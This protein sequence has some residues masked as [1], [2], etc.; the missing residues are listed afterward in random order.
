[1]NK[2]DAILT[3]DWHL[4]EDTPI[5]RTDNF[6]E[7]QWKKVS[8]VSNLQKKYN[9]PVL[10]T[11]DLF[12][13]WKPSP[14]LLS[15]TILYLPKR[16]ITIYGNHDLPQHN[17]ELAFKSGVRTLENAFIINDTLI[18]DYPFNIVCND[19]G[20]TP[21]DNPTGITNILLWHIYTYQTKNPNIIGT[22]ARKILK[23]YPSYNLIV[24]GDNHTPFVEEFEGRLLVNP[25]SL[26]R[27]KADQIDHKP[28]VYLWNM[29]ENIVE[30]VYLPIDKVI[31]REHLISHEQ[32]EERINAFISRLDTT[33]EAGLSFEDN[34]K[35][36][37]KKNTVRKSVIDIIY[38]SLE[39]T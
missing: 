36:F 14:N 27:Q 32:K 31:S 39:L 1:M 30:P 29:Q 3:A 38:K 34:L 10:H 8:F 9:C 33:W 28:R 20:T 25:G 21:I 15:N 37:Q 18:E 16:F 19:F 11:G 6:W 22:H 5:C 7:T 13:N 12:D 35:I 24:T 2:V 4:R 23:N 17:V 26:M